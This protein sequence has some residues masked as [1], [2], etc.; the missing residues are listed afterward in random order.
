M[1]IAVCC[2]MIWFQHKWT[3]L[4]LFGSHGQF[5]GTNTFNNHNLTLHTYKAST[6][7]IFHGVMMVQK[8]MGQR[9]NVTPFAWE[10]LLCSS[11]PYKINLA[12]L[13]Q[14]CAE[15]IFTE[16][17]PSSKITK[18]DATGT[19]SALILKNLYL[20]FVKYN[21]KYITFSLTVMNTSYIFR[22]ADKYI[23]HVG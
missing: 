5:P 14:Y 9:E 8:D 3:A 23:F 15:S 2:P 21:V 12:E 4:L 10:I 20:K 7:F 11:S 19:A 17:T 6:R 13:Q 1:G 16:L 22:C 18:M